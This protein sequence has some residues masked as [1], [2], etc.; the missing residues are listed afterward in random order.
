M[1]LIQTIYRMRVKKLRAEDPILHISHS[2]EK[3][4]KR[5]E[6]AFVDLENGLGGMVYHG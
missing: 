5:G 1:T 4:L 3:V 6:G 2:N